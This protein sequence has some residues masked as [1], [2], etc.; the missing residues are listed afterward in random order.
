[1]RKLRHALSAL[2][3]LGPSAAFA[4]STDYAYQ[5]DIDA[6]EQPLQRVD[7]PLEVILALTRADLGDLAVFN[8]DGRQLVHSIT[9]A[10]AS[11]RE[12]NRSLPYESPQSTPQ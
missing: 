3:L 2:L 9:R 11:A 1:M 7:L 10:P 6:A 5:A 12:L 8:A 4:A